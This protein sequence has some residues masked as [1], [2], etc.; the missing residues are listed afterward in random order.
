M[1]SILDPIRT[2]TD[3]RAGATQ[4]G[5]LGYIGGPGIYTQRIVSFFEKKC[6]E[7]K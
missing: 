3:P 6:E 2:I 1:F 7:Q 4:R 5:L